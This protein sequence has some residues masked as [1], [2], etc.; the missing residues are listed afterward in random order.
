MVLSKAFKYS[1][2]SDGDAMVVIYSALIKYFTLWY[3]VM[4]GMSFS[5]VTVAVVVIGV[6]D[7]IVNV[8]S[9]VTIP[10]LCCYFSSY[11]IN[12]SISIDPS[13]GEPPSSMFPCSV[14][15]PVDINVC[16]NL[17]S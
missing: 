13:N 1:E 5:A 7:D 11:F 12:T 2:V 15:P 17:E 4:R 10:A 3:L 6:D 9:V 14:A 16:S 8:P